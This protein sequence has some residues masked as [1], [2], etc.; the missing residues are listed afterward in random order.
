M[1][2]D[3]N[4]M[5]TGFLY[6]GFGFMHSGGRFYSSGP[7]FGLFYDTERALFLSC[8]GRNNIGN[9]EWEILERRVN[10]I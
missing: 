3:Q 2:D 6:I 8:S 10:E 7:L 9:G 5:G 1:I 4:M